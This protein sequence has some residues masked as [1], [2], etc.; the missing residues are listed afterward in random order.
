LDAILRDDDMTFGILQSHIHEVWAL[1]LCTWLGVGN[2]PRYTPTTTFELFP[3]PNGLSPDV[4]MVN[5]IDN[6]IARHIGEA[7]KHLNELREQWLNP[8]ELVDSVPEVV[9][10]YPAR[11]LPRNEGAAKELKRRTLTNLYNTNPEWLQNAHRSLDEAVATAYG[12]DWP[13]ADEEIL[14]RLID[15]NRKVAD[16][17]GTRPLTH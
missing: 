2:D 5:W 1:R 7:A 17:A 9:S 6:P 4:S 15:L 13:L 3:F 16:I 10:G 14:Q 8:A 12:W 11:L